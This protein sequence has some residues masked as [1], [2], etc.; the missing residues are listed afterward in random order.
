M[1]EE[2]IWPG[3]GRMVLLDNEINVGD[4]R[5][6]EKGEDECWEAKSDINNTYLLASSMMETHQQRSTVVPT[7]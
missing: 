5:A 2:F 1:D 7:R 6:N 3:S 4:G